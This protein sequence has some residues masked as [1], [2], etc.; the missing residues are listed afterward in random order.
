[1]AN[2]VELGIKVDSSAVEAATAA[3]DRLT[4]SIERASEA[5]KSLNGADHGGIEIHAVG[6]IVE[7]IVK[8]APKG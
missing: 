2:T 6:E 4:A 5:L 1:M 3:F 8:P 7:C